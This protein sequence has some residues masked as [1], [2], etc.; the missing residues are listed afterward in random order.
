MGYIETWLSESWAHQNTYKVTEEVFK[1]DI[2]MGESFRITEWFNCVYHGKWIFFQSRKSLINQKHKYKVWQ[3]YLYFDL[4]LGWLENWDLK[5]L[6]FFIWHKWW[7]HSP[8]NIKYHKFFRWKYQDIFI[9]F[10]FYG[11]NLLKHDF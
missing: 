6:S 9:S 1:D 11:Q 10:I 8:S 4:V 5:W 3:V 7:D 2:Y